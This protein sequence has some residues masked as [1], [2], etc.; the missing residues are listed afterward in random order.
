MSSTPTS[1]SSP[2]KNDDSKSLET[3]NSQK[4]EQ[5]VEEKVDSSKQQE[6]P[7]KDLE[8]YRNLLAKET[9]IEYDIYEV[10]ENPPPPLSREE[11]IKILQEV[12]IIPYS[13]E[14]LYPGSIVLGDE[15][16][17]RLRESRK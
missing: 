12:N 5:K 8:Y 4:I 3:T 1:S 14:E 7:I 6:E 16:I 17:K 15:E 10:E 2:S 11:K 13:L 9:G